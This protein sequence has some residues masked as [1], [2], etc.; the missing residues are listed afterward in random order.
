M[1]A[2]LTTDPARIQARTTPVRPTRAQLL[3][4]LAVKLLGHGDP[5]D[6]AALFSTDAV[7]RPGDYAPA[8]CKATGPDAVWATSQWLR[9]AFGDLDWTIRAVAGNGPTVV[10]A[11]GMSGRHRGPLTLH[12]RHGVP[13]RVIPASGLRFTVAR[14]YRFRI[15]GHRIVERSVDFGEL[16]TLGKDSR[17]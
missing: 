12:D 5:K 15:A 7:N 6:F 10:V 14:T 1:T 4:V 3:A 2:A 17:P 8:V 9:R 16:G 13:T 11:A